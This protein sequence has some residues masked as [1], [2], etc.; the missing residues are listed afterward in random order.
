MTHWMRDPTAETTAVK[1]PRVAPPKSLDGITVALF[2]IGKARSDEFLDQ[3]ERRL[4]ERGVKT[5]RYAKPTNAKVAPTEVMQ[6]VAT[7]AQAVIIGL[8]D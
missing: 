8:S 5:K 2:E 1:R 4:T 3:V 6:R 7:E